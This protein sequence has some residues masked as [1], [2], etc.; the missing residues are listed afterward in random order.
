MTRENS[1]NRA[2]GDPKSSS[3]DLHP[4]SR[5]ISTANCKNFSFFQFTQPRPFSVIIWNMAASFGGAISL[6]ISI[7]S[8]KQMIW[9]HTRRVIAFM[10]DLV[11]LTYWPKMNN[12]GSSMSRNVLPFLSF[13]GAIGILVRAFHCSNPKP[14]VLCFIDMLPKAFRYRYRP[15]AWSARHIT[16]TAAKLFT[17]ITRKTFLSALLAEKGIDFCNLFLIGPMA[18]SATKN[19]KRAWRRHEYALAL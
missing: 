2:H 5:F 18:R 4:F 19:S 7:C 8:Y 14:A 3:Q 16:I 11:S 9:P 6:I 1:I 13:Q 12:P 15:C 10:K 17:S